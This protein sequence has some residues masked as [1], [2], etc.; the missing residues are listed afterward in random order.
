M[1]VFETLSNINLLMQSRHWYA[2]GTFK[3]CSSIFSHMYTIHQM[4]S[5]VS[6]PLVYALRP[7]KR[8]ET[9]IW[10][11]K[12]FQS[13]RPLHSPC[14]IVLILKWLQWVQL[15]QSI[16]TAGT[17][18]DFFTFANA[19]FGKFSNNVCNLG[20]LKINCLLSVCS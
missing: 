9:Y 1:I 3:S 4:D 15:K 5:A 6:I 13:Y 14:S 11:M 12:F 8:K 10:L 7:E 20:I 19:Y 18:V 17:D 2:N 16:Q